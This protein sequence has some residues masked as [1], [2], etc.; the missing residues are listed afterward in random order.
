MRGCTLVLLSLFVTLTAYAI[1]GNAVAPLISTL[2]GDLGI[3]I[4]RFGLLIMLQ[5]VAFAAASFA[6]GAL[7][8]RLG[9]SNSPMVAAGLAILTVSF[10]A[11]A[12]ALRSGTSLI[13]WIIPL[14]LAGGSVETFASLEVSRLSRD[15]SSRNLCLSQAFYSIGAFIA[16]QAVYLVFRAGLGWRPVLVVFG[17][18]SAAILAFFLTSTVRRGGFAPV[19]QAGGAAPLA[20]RAAGPAFVLLLLLILPVV[21]MESISASWLAYVFETHDGLGPKEAALVLALFWAAMT[22]G[23]F[24]ILLVPARLSLWPT[25]AVSALGVL[26]VSTGLAAAQGLALRIALVALL[27]LFIAPL[28][29]VI[30]MTTSAAFG[31]DRLTSALIGTGALGFAAGPAVG[32]LIMR[33]GWARRFFLVHTGLGL[34]MVALC[35]AAWRIATRAQAPRSSGL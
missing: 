15:G 28:W 25:L 16:P 1:S 14:G 11:G 6:G 2:A 3:A 24:A 32:A 20:A 17:L 5:F 31:S 7:K 19:G 13:A 21:V 10:F 34:L 4:P 27:G 33:L 8:E 9:L 29:P 26:A 35:F 12:L 18:F 22:A 23:R 30:V